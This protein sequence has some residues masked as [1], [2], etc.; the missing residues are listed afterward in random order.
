MVKLAP[1]PHI[2]LNFLHH[3]AHR[4]RDRKWRRWR[5]LLNFLL[6]WKTVSNC[7]K[8]FKV[9]LRPLIHFFHFVDNYF[10]IV[11]SSICFTFFRSISFVFKS[12]GV[13]TIWLR[14]FIIYQLLI[15]RSWNRLLCLVY[16][17]TVSISAWR[18]LERWNRIRCSYIFHT[19]TQSVNC[20]R[21]MNIR[22]LRPR[23]SVISSIYK[24]EYNYTSLPIFIQRLQF[25]NRWEWW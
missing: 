20:D 17:I 22:Q 19:F 1:T 18:V 9:T 25:A 16:E 14:G 3:I 21:W 7:E 24:I 8:L 15:I 23:I 6:Q 5:F 4:D 10:V 12:F 2:A 11:R 13:S